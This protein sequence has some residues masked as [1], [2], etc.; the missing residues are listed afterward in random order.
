MKLLHR[1]LLCDVQIRLSVISAW[2][3]Q[4]HHIGGLIIVY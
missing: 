3:H 2:M 1:V 4:M